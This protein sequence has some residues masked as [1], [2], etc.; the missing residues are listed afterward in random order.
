MQFQKKTS[1]GKSSPAIKLLI[2]IMLIIAFLFL[3]VF[4]TDKINFPHPSKK[5]QKNIINENFK[6]VK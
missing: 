3:L 2:K 5:I 6:V 4:L 1:L